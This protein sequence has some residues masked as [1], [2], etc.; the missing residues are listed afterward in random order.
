MFKAVFLILSGNMFVSL[1][2]LVRNLLVARLISIENYGIA[3]TFAMSMAI[4]E[5]MTALGIQQ[6]MIQD[7]DGNDPKL[8]AALQGF[9][10]LRSLFTGML[11]F[12]LAYPIALFLGTSEIAWAYQLLAIVP[13]INGFYHFDI[14]RLQ[15]KMIYLPSLL[16]SFV[17]AL[18]SVLLV[19]PLFAIYGDYRVMLYAII[20]QSIFGL[21]TSHL[22]A[23]RPYRFVFDFSIIGRIVNFG[24]PLLI[25]NIMLFA[26]FHGEKLIVGRELGMK[27]LAILAMGLTLTLTPSQVMATTA[28]TF[29]LPQLSAAKDDNVRFSYLSIVT[30]QTSLLNGLILVTGVVFF[31]APIVDLLLGEKYHALIPY[32]VWLSIMQ[33]ARVFKAG[34][35]VIAVAQGKT[36]NAM[37]GNM[38]RVISLP[39]SWYVLS[40]GGNLQ[41][42]IWIAIVAE[43]AGYTM[44]L[45]LVHYRIGLNLTQMVLPIVSA[46][47]LLG[48]SCWYTLWFPAAQG[49]SKIS[50]YAA[51]VN[52]LILLFALV[53]M[54]DLR[55]YFFNRT[56]TK[57][58]D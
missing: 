43:C 50:F 7:K 23:E 45:F 51:F 34:S 30:L 46:T 55:K 2:L 52:M 42:V 32:L 10:S 38:F 37:V 28:Q 5:M 16:S 44:S 47:C 9:H 21:I 41:S 18:I 35:A 39:L 49:T 12:F 56:L 29:F 40:T 26:V 20:A 1:I 58:S 19:M 25:N 11:L 57:Y 15:R 17:P 13:I 4:V 31:G 3:A 14:Y 22:V 8:Q 6:L 53:S 48:F 33:A 24:W 36:E 54:K 27:D